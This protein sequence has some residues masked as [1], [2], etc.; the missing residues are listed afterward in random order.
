MPDLVQAR[1]GIL[2]FYPK[3]RTMFEAIANT[4]SLLVDLVCL[5]PEF[6]PLLFLS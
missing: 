4:F 3:P 6:I 5:I 2:L 1:S